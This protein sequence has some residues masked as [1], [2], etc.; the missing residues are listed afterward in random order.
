MEENKEIKEYDERGNLIY[1]K[2]SLGTEV[3]REYN[4]NNKVIYS[5]DSC[6]FKVWTGYNENNKLIYSKDSLGSEYFYKYEN[7][8]RIG[9]NR[10]E[11]ERIKKEQE[12]LNREYCSR[13]DIMDI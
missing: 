1:Y 9:I 6:G 5:K 2:N 11:F 7:N 8:K 13:F 4:E 3:W 12:F 10:Q